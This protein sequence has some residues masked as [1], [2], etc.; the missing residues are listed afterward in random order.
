MSRRSFRGFTLANLSKHV[1]QARYF[2]V[3]C[4]GVLMGCVVGDIERLMAVGVV[5]SSRAPSGSETHAY[6]DF[7]DFYSR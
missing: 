5:Y 7:P 6:H 1:L 3:Y 2:D 4:N